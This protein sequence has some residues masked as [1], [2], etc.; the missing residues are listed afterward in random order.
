MRSL[1]NATR[2]PLQVNDNIGD[3]YS[4]KRSNSGF[5]WLYGFGKKSTSRQNLHKP[6]LDESWVG[7]G[8]PSSDLESNKEEEIMIGVFS[9]NGWAVA[10]RVISV[11]TGMANRNSVC[12]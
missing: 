1:A 5:N 4:M 9:S 2:K 3:I 12:D 10:R 7:F 6:N 8:S 11:D